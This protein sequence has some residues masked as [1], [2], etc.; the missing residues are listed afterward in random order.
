MTTRLLVWTSVL[1]AAAVLAACGDDG[2]ANEDSDLIVSG[3]SS[4]TSAFTAYG[5]T[6]DEGRVRFS[7]AGS[8]DLAAQIRQ[9]VRPDVYAAANTSLPEALHAEGLVEAPVVFAANRLVLAVP[10]EGAEVRSLAD[11]AKPGVTIAMGSED[12]PIGAYAREVLSRLGEARAEA[13][14]ANVRSNEPDVK[15]IVGKLAQGA[16]D[17]GF[18]YV[19][20]VAAASGALTAIELPQQL[21]PDV[22]YGVAVVTGAPNPERARRFVAGLLAG[23]GERA[24]R[25]AGFLPPP[26]AG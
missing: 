7:F 5:E 2:K 25:A 13:I 22:A 26:P 6:F 12:A 9:G 20:D 4:L 14:L 23:D 24:L 1:S 21:Q 8:D 11:L 16:V 10:A 18:V 19:T 15:G 17:A 3:A